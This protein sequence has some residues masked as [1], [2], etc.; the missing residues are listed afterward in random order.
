M[1]LAM[2]DACIQRN[3]RNAVWIQKDKIISNKLIKFFTHGD[4]IVICKNQRC[5]QEETETQRNKI[6]GKIGGGWGRVD[7]GG[8]FES[9]K[10]TTST[11]KKE[12]C[13]IPG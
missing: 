7:L 6:K 5:I 12:K 8:G 9:K 2:E 11:K 1:Y 10:P 3:L 4:Q 13:C